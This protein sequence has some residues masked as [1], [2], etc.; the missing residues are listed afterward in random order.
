MPTILPRCR[1]GARAASLLALLLSS[2]GAPWASAQSGRLALP[3]GT[4]VRVLDRTG[5]APFTGSVLRITPDTLAIAVS[6]GRALLQLPTSRLST[7]EVSEGRDRLG[8][9]WKGAGIGVLVGGIA[10]AASLRERDDYGLATLAGF[11]AGGLIGGG[12]GAV[13][14]AIVAPERWTRLALPG[15]GR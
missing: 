7:L 3:V 10:G 8:V 2:L 1:R 11:F 4:R 12:L 5:G 9:A 13:V 6:D 15:A 14:G